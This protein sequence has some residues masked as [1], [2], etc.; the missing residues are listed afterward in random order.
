MITIARL[1]PRSL[2]LILGLFLAAPLCSAEP[3]VRL[4]AAD[5]PAFSAT[6]SPTTNVFHPVSP[7]PI[8]GAIASATAYM[9]TNYH[10]VKKPFDGVT[11]SQFLDRY[12]ETLDPQHIHFTQAD[13][14]DFE[15]YR[16]NL[17]RLT[18]PGQHL[19]DTR[20]A[21]EIFN[22][23]MERLQQRTAYADELL[24]HEKFTFDKDERILIN[25]KQV[26]YPADLDE[27]KKLWR[28][29]LRFEY[30]QELLGKI[31]AR[32]KNLAATK[33]KPPQ[34]E[35]RPGALQRSARQRAESK[36]RRCRP[37]LKKDSRIRRLQ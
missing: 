29:R 21:C 1:A 30:L 15:P 4:T 9:L 34:A 8:D 26:P 24:Q 10:Y 16:T 28:E 20:P 6:F 2:L 36:S 31:G 13:L 11:S 19:G 17:N 37:P 27:A 18:L 12:L 22:R 25:R 33:S 23:Y 14:A 32:K 5:Q 7:G 3:V 35:T